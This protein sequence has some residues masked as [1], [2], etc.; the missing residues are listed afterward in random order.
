MTLLNVEG[1]RRRFGGRQV[2]DDVS[3]RVNSGEMVGLLGPNGAGKTTTFRMIL[4]LVRPDAGS[5]QFKDKEI[6]REPVYQR[7]RLGL[8][9]LSQE[10]S[11]FRGMTV[12]EN[13]ETVLEWMPE[14]RKDER[15]DIKDD[16]LHRFHLDHLRD[17]KASFLSGGEQR[18]LEIARVLARSPS[19][20]LL[21]EPFANVDPRTV[22][23]LQELLESL[24]TEGIGILITD[25]NVRETLSVTD[26][27]YILVDGR[28]LQHGTAEELVRD[29]LVRR[30]YL[31]ERFRMP[32]EREEIKAARR[33]RIAIDEKFSDPGEELPPHLDR[34]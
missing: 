31:G 32:D 21:D 12:E 34:T 11:T 27:S 33:H 29:P 5:I 22:E 4:G 8:G 7:A 15:A 19:L 17:Q 23:E 25:H 14:L 24:R 1:L 9:Y 28:I 26:R 10:P 16:L 6:A 30:M 18:R 3:L 2:V 13:L 20:V